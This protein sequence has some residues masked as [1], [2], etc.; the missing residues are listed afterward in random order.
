MTLPNGK[1]VEPMVE[2]RG[3]FTLL[4]KDT[5][6]L[7]VSLTNRQKEYVFQLPAISPKGISV[8]YLPDKEKLQISEKNVTAGAVSVF[9][10]GKLVYFSR[11]TETVDCRQFPTGVNEITVYDVEGAPLATRQIFVNH[12]DLGV[13]V[14]PRLLSAEGHPS[15]QASAYESMKLKAEL[16]DNKLHTMSISVRVGNYDELTYDDGNLQTDLLLAGDLRGF[17]SHPDYYFEGDDKK[18]RARLDLLLMI[19]GWR[20]YKQ[21]EKIRYQPEKNLRLEGQ[22]FPLTPYLAE[23]ICELV[24]KNSLDARNPCFKG[25]VRTDW[26]PLPED[27]KG[28]EETVALV[29]DSLHSQQLLV[30][31]ELCKG[32]DVL[33]LVAETDS[34]GYFS[35]YVPPF[36]GKAFLFMTAYQRKDSVARCLSSK[37]DKYKFNLSASP[38]YQIAR[39]TFYP[40]FCSPYSWFQTHSIDEVYSDKGVDE[41]SVSG[42]HLLENVIVQS[43][44]KLHHHFSYVTP[45]FTLDYSQVVNDVIDCGLLVGAVQPLFLWDR[46]SLYLFG[47]MNKPDERIGAMAS[48]N[49]HYFWK[50]NRKPRVGSD[51]RVGELMSARQ[52]QRHLDSRFIRKV[53]VYT[54]YDMRL[55]IGK[56]RTGMSP[57]VYYDVESEPEGKR[58]ITR[59]DRCLLIDGF[60]YPEQFYHRDYSGQTPR[61]SS[62]YRRT[63]YWNP[64]ARVDADGKLQ[65][66]FYNGARPAY[67][68]VSMCGISEE[69]KIYYTEE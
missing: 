64:N 69:G 44:Q 15:S 24:E 45:A 49:G 22:V 11:Q 42:A 59:R 13:K 61:D 35:F 34:L 66:K 8:C 63:L 56:D 58:N 30:E 9:C 57:D 16:H 20:K 52:L 14:K 38:Y 10:R 29:D 4:P 6:V 62:D 7:Y 17:V 1:K 53:R 23:S 39:E 67:L 26:S 60:A 51:D 50:S 33:N 2:G 55:G 65:V 54:D 48:V 46:I 19:Q 28:G 36:Y 32:D 12:Q 43:K 40:K 3:V 5:S 41:D 31:A 18:H 21:E 37:L 25:V 27:N 47:N 68:R